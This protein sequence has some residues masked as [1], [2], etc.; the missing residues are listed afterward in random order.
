MSFRPKEEWGNFLWSFIHTISIVDME[1]NE[2]YNK[3]AFEVLRGLEHCI[4]CDK[5][6]VEYKKSLELLDNID[7]SK[8]MVLFYWS[9]D[10]HNKVNKK[11][12]KKEWTYDM[13]LEKWSK[14]L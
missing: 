14:K 2:Y 6:K 4:P 1:Q 7:L 10:L 5:C 3:M 12:S 9:V 11:L 13:A 8:K